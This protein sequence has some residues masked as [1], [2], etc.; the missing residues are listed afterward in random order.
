M[1]NRNKYK[2][3]IKQRGKKQAKKELLHTA[4]NNLKH[5][6]VF[7]TEIRALACPFAVKKTN[8]DFEQ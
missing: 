1:D 8:I 2:L 3:K 7:W 4:V 5:S 6:K